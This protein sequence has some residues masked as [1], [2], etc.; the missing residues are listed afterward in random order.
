MNLIDIGIALLIKC[1][2][3]NSIATSIK[4]RRPAVNFH[5]C[6]I[7]SDFC[8]KFKIARASIC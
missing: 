5:A 3:K 2:C 6:C 7:T 8:Y 1:H 4:E